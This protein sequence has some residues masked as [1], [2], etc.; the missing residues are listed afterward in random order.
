MSVTYPRCAKSSVV[1]EFL[2]C[3]VEEFLDCPI[4]FGAGSDEVAHSLGMSRRTLARRL[5]DERLTFAA[6]LEGVWLD[7]AQH[8]L[9]DPDL[10]VSRIALAAR[11]SGDQ[12]LHEFLQAMDRGHPDANACP[13]KR[14]QRAC[15][16]LIRNRWQRAPRR[17]LSVPNC[18]GSVPS[19][20]AG[21]APVFKLVGVGISR[22][23]KCERE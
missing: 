2:D 14:Q 5:A 17:T 23:P 19:R 9:K 22:R 11:L 4:G 8:Y 6:I 10:P 16:G 20:Q 21:S 1:E 12:R 3:L 7:L 13:V 15:F 18:Q